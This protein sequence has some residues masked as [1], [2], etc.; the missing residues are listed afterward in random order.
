ME[1]SELLEK[2]LVRVKTGEVVKGQVVT[3]D[4]SGVIVDIGYKSEGLVPIDEFERESDGTL[5]IKPGDDIDVFVISKE[6]PTGL[7]ALSKN[8]AEKQ[9]GSSDLTTAFHDHTTLQGKVL[10]HN[11]SG[12]MVE[13][14]GTPVSCLFHN[15]D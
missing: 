13:Y 5:G 14:K 1:F 9:Q 11:K 12:F 3:V 10:S 6:T 7:V 15:Q 8:M 2:E 4:S